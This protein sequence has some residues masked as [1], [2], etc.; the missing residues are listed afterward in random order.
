[1]GFTDKLGLGLYIGFIRKE[2][3]ERV[4][5]VQS[6]CVFPGGIWKGELEEIT[7]HSYFGLLNVP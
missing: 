3:R 5:K 6:D 1:M 2:L 4:G 7:G